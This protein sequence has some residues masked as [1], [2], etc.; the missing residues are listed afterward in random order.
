MQQPRIQAL[1]LVFIAVLLVACS[2][3]YEQAEMIKKEVKHYVQQGSWKVTKYVRYNEDKTLEWSDALLQFKSN[4]ILHVITDSNTYSGWW[5]VLVLDETFSGAAYDY[6][7]LNIG[8]NIH[9]SL[10]SLNEDWNIVSYSSVKIELMESV[11][12][13]SLMDVLT[14]EKW[15]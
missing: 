11:P 6:V 9:E 4:D 5:K 10:D 14:I 15:N 2:K 13:T 7:N 3:K 1:L 12:D 8:F